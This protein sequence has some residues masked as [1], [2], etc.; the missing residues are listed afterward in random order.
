MQRFENMTQRNKF[1]PSR[2][3]QKRGVFC[4]HVTTMPSKSFSI[5][6]SAH[7]QKSSEGVCTAYLRHGL[8]RITSLPHAKTEKWDFLHE[9]KRFF[10]SIRKTDETDEKGLMQS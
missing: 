2:H 4:T 8:I 3:F 7:K 6:S 9:S 5:F 10:H 1:E